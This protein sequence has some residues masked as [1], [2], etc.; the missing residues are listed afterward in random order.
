VCSS[1]S[2]SS[3]PRQGHGVSSQKTLSLAGGSPSSSWKSTAAVMEVH[4]SL[5]CPT[6][7]VSGAFLDMIVCV[8]SDLC[9]EYC[10]Q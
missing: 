10:L 5:W 1:H 9:E 6:A 2:G 7:A 8:E 3:R 4:W